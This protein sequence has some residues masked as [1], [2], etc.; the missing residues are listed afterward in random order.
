MQQDLSLKLVVAIETALV[1]ERFEVRSG[2][3]RCRQAY[4]AVVRAQ[5][6]GDARY[7]LLACV[8][9]KHCGHVIRLTFSNVIQ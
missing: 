6:A 7:N 9:L 2:L 5:P 4:T 8:G 1:D 3:D